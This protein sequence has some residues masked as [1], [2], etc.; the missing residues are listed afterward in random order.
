[1][2]APEFCALTEETLDRKV[3]TM[4]GDQ[5]AKA[6]TTVLLFLLEPQEP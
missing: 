6:N 4:L 3:S 5:S 1:M 2:A